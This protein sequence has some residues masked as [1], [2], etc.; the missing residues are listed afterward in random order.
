[1]GCVRCGGRQCR[2]RGT[3]NGQWRACRAKRTGRVAAD[4]MPMEHIVVVGDPG[5]GKSTLLSTMCKGA[6]QF[7]SGLSIG[8]GMT[9]ALQTE[10]V[11]GKRYSDTPGLNDASKKQAAANAI[12]DAIILGGAVK[13]IF[14]V[15]LEAGRLRQSNLA[16]VRLVLDALVAKGI[17]V[18]GL[19]SIIIN[20]MS[21][22]EVVGWNDP[23]LGGPALLA[24]QINRGFAADLLLFLGHV[25]LLVDAG[26]S[27]LPAAEAARL[28]GM[29]AEMRSMTVPRGTHIDVK[30]DELEAL[31]ERIVRELT[32]MRTENQEARIALAA[33]LTKERNEALAKASESKQ[34]I[35]AI[36][37]R[38]EDDMRRVRGAHNVW[39]AVSSVASAVGVALPGIFRV[40]AIAQ[41][42]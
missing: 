17:Q 7:K 10:V 27:R 30:V 12:S 39:T 23:A 11:D 34:D 28:D 19:F 22:G 3:R 32:A 14:V 40:I 26:D 36:K 42:R 41:R 24:D 35:D 29:L 38:Y 4:A 16:T 20:K 21:P 1:M 25:P 2:R 8:T 33:Q 9:A 13:L 15:T 6:A 5:T 18:D 37:A 31:T